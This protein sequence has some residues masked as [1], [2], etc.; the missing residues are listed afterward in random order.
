M[1]KGASLDKLETGGLGSRLGRASLSRGGI[2]YFSL[3]PH[4]VPTGSG[5]EF[6][7]SREGV[8]RGETVVPTRKLTDF[9]PEHR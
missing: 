9:A 6:L 3:F 2:C 8:G 1:R 7:E 4:P 5:S